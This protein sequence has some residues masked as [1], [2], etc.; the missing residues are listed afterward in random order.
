M[1]D[2][3]NIK[4]AISQ[5]EDAINIFKENAKDKVY[6]VQN[7]KG[8]M[9]R[10]QEERKR[11][12]ADHIRLHNAINALRS[13]LGDTKKF[14]DQIGDRPYQE[15]IDAMNNV[16]QAIN[17]YR[18]LNGSSAVQE[19]LLETSR[20]LAPYLVPMQIG[21]ACING[22]GTAEVLIRK[23]EYKPES[24]NISQERRLES[25]LRM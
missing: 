15:K 22:G 11:T 16:L 5:T 20:E 2:V 21:L 23:D 3:R 24:Q 9:V 14:L 13:Q 12:D 19:V 7:D 1:I 18:S 25:P 10:D 4:E 8:V 17:L 6:F